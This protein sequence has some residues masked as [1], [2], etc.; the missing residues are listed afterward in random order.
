MLIAIFV[1]LLFLLFGM[2]VAFAIGI[3]GMFFFLITPELPLS[4]AAQRTVA[5]TQSYT[6]L[7]IPLFVFAGN[8]M[9]NTGIT[10]RLI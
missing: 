6:L 8:L 1:F 10:K 7:A 9:N 3:S 4:I 2:P 5:S